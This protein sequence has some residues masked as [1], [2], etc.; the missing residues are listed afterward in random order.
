MLADLGNDPRQLR[1]PQRRHLA[2]LQR[3]QPFAQ[4]LGHRPVR[5]CLLH[6]VATPAQNSDV[7][8]LQAADE[9]LGQPRLADARIP[10]QNHGAALTSFDPGPLLGQRRQF[11]LA[12]D[13]R[14]IEEGRVLGFAQQRPVSPAAAHWTLADALDQRD[15][16][17]SRRGLQ[18][19]GQ[20]ALQ[21][22]VALEG[23]GPVP[24]HPERPHQL[25]VRRLVEWIELNEPL[26]TAP[27][28]G[29]FTAL[30]RRPYRRPQRLAGER[31]HAR[32]LP[33]RPLLEALGAA[34]PEALEEMSTV[35][36]RRRPGLAGPEQPFQFD[37]VHPQPVP[38]QLQ[39]LTR[40]PHGAVQQPAHG[41]E[42]L[43]E[44]MARARVVAVAPEQPGQP[45][46]A[47]GAIGVEREIG[48][49]REM[50]A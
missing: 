35:Q 11:R 2:Q 32:L 36:V 39:I 33:A 19:G 23:R 18:L 27:D 45:L 44:R 37:G 10:D 29:P 50:L 31:A 43:G 1:Q 8:Q 41:V 14:R 3:A 15:R 25:G 38:L 48:E 42:R 49:K 26:G 22:L 17:G 21:H 9:F 6:L 5:E 13:E 40:D 4:R 24:Q 20:N 34:E 7:A 30:A 12:A 28:L 16:L 46:A 47:V